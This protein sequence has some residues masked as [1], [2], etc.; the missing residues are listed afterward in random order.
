MFYV[1]NFVANFEAPCKYI[2]KLYVSF[3]IMISY[4]FC[5]LYG[6]YGT[7]Y[8]WLSLLAPCCVDFINIFV[9]LI[10]FIL[11]EWC[12]SFLIFYRLVW[13]FVCVFVFEDAIGLICIYLFLVST[14]CVCCPSSSLLFVLWVLIVCPRSINLT[15]MN[16]AIFY[17]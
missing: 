16:W 2:F 7:L 12:N 1:Y 5:A 14:I 10:N 6:L 9:I 4:L 17:K 3:S 11:S 13:V 15:R 8:R